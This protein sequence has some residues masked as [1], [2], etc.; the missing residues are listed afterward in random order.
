MHFTWYLDLQFDKTMDDISF[1]V[2][3]N[4]K[5]RIMTW[6]NIKCVELELTPEQSARTLGHLTC[7]SM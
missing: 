3:G 1:V 5:F 7:V 4:D 2:L 6:I